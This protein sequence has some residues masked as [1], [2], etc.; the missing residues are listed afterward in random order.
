MLD[1]CPKSLPSLCPSLRP[2]S[3]VPRFENFFLL[4]IWHCFHHDDPVTNENNITTSNKEWARRFH[5][6][7]NLI[8]HTQ[9]GPD[10]LVYAN[11]DRAFLAS[12]GDDTLR[13]GEPATHPNPC[14]WHFETE[15]DC[16]LW[17]HTEVS[18]V[19]LAAWT[20]YGRVTQTSH[21]CPT[22][23]HFVTLLPCSMSEAKKK[24][25]WERQHL[26]VLNSSPSA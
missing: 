6:L 25:V 23:S 26:L 2:P 21:T 7:R 9:V 18:N 3:L 20:Q 12:C 8:V 13:M 24:Y 22:S 11:W 5:P 15:A 10:G 19:V 1:D 16:E 4:V 17:F 14:L